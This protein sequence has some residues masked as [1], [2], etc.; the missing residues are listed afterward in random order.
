MPWFWRSSTLAVVV[1]V[2]LFLVV[3]VVRLTVGD[4]TDAINMLYTLPIALL[5]LAFGLRAG[6]L[7]GAA[8]V[9]LIVGWVLVDDVALT[10]LGWASRVIPMLLL[11]LVLGDASDRLRRAEDER[12]T[13][14]QAAQRH[15]DAVEIN[16]TLVQ[17]MTAAKWALE[18]GRLEAGLGTLDETLKLGHQLV[19]KLLREADMGMNG[20]RASLTEDSPQPRPAEDA[21]RPA[22]HGPRAG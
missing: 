11:G 16:D 15:R 20:H 9:A 19:S 18:A 3:F 5:A 12:R 10:P 2:A 21:P 8:S 14:E 6:A 17:G 22:Q 7:A 4:A 13:L 1:A